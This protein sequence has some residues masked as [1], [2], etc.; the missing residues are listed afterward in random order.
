MDVLWPD[1]G[2][3]QLDAAIAEFAARERNFGAVPA[4][5]A[6]SAAV[7]DSGLAGAGRNLHLGG[8]SASGERTS[9]AMS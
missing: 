9:G 5:Q 8:R 6:G 3:D 7:A 4:T 2:P 1:F